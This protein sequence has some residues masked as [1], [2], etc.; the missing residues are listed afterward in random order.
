LTEK[1]KQ[2]FTNWPSEIWNY[3]LVVT[4]VL[5]KKEAKIPIFLGSR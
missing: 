5:D 2:T 4:N 1:D 3:D